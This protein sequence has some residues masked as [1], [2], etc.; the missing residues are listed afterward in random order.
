MTMT[1]YKDEIKTKDIVWTLYKTDKGVCLIESD[2]D[3]PS[4]GEMFLTKV[5][6][7]YRLVKDEDQFTEERQQMH[8]FFEGKRT[9]LE[10]Q[11]QTFGTTFQKQVWEAVGRVPYGDTATY[12]DIANMINRPTAIRAVS[13]AIGQNPLLI[14][15]PCHRV[16]GKDGS[17][18]GYRSGLS[19]KQSLLEL[20]NKNIR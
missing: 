14:H 5:F 12:T 18:T 7:S 8:A 11:V 9:G 2:R 17:L 16:I 3:L 13:R 15:C 10:F 4:F 19:L 20:E 6:G 1:L